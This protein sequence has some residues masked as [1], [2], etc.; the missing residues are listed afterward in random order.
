MIYFIRWLATLGILY[1]MQ[2]IYPIFAIFAYY[3]ELNHIPIEIINNPILIF[4]LTY[5][6]LKLVYLKFYC[7]W[8]FFRL[9]SI[10]DHIEAPENQQACISRLTNTIDFW[11]NWHASYNKW[12]V[13]Y[14]YIPNGG[15]KYK[16]KNTFIV[17]LFVIFTHDPN[18]KHINK[19]M[20]WGIMMAIAIGIETI[21]QNLFQNYI[22]NK[23]AT[24]MIIYI[25][26]L[27]G[28]FSIFMLLI[29]NMIAYGAG[30]TETSYFITNGIGSYQIWCQIFIWMF[31]VSYFRLRYMEIQQFK[32]D[33]LKKKKDKKANVVGV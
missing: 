31:A 18:F 26:V 16:V 4:S 24:W 17:F 2:H 8:R 9:W 29:A 23:I 21:I 10:F 33:Q 27:G 15:S 13:K 5:Y 1:I 7:I 19:Y 22:Y 30:S 32:I 25:K 20:I 14:I 11:K 6:G 28:I 3:A 12:L